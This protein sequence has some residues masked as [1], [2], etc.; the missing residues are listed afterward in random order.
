MFLYIKREL[1][2]LVVVVVVVVV[3]YL[4]TTGK[5]T[6]AI[7]MTCLMPVM[8]NVWEEKKKIEE[9]EKELLQKEF[10]TFIER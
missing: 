3:F 4:K 10:E 5:T 9:E 8:V 1:S 6:H 7:Q 2:L